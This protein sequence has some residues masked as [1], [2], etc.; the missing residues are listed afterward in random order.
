[1]D[2]RFVTRGVELK[3]D[4]KDYMENKMSK[5]ERFFSRIIDG[6]VVMSF[7]RGLFTVEI[8]SNANGSL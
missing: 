2:I 7:G 1:M 3:D 5:L 8:T 6:Q 4:L